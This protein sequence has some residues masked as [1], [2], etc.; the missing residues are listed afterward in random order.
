MTKKLEIYYIS[1]PRGLKSTDW[2]IIIRT[3]F[4]KYMVTNRKINQNQ[5]IFY[6]QKKNLFLWELKSRIRFSC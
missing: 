3:M 1:M 6:N 5:N 4:L 2:K